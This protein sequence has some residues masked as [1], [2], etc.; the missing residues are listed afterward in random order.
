[1]VLQVNIVTLSVA[2]K[3]GIAPACGCVNKPLVP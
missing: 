1:M 2:V 3:S